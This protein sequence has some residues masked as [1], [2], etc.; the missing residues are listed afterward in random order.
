MEFS[1]QM[2]T[3][4]SGVEYPVQPGDLLRQA[5]RGGVPQEEIEQLAKLPNREFHGSI[6]VARTIVALAHDKQAD[7]V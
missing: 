3:L 1:V 4:L 5:E 6:D 2:T 7:A